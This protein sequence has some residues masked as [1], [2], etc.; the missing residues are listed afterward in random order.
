M[1]DRTLALLLIGY[2]GAAAWIV[3]EWQ[4]PPI[5][6][7]IIEA[8]L[9]S[10]IPAPAVP[11]SFAVERSVFNEIS[12]RPLFV[13]GRRPPQPQTE[14]IKTTPQ[15]P[16]TPTQDELDT[17]RLTAVLRDAEQL[18]ALIE[19][20]DGKTSVVRSGERVGEWRIKAIFDDRL[21]FERGG[22]ART[23]RLHRFDLPPRNPPVVRRTP[24][25]AQARAK[26]QAQDPRVR[27]RP[28][29]GMPDTARPAQAL[30][31]GAEPQ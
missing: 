3:Y 13:Q 8:P 30:P 21:D 23:L 11:A 27:Q 25:Q 12:E 28:V 31:E 6:T 29:R 4:R 9:A 7:D 26:V 24:A 18:I 19:Y 10:K 14:V 22:Q 15:R 20:A 16:P 17:V 2:A 5:M 1:F